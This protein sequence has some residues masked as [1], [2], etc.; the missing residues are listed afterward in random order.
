MSCYT[1]QN[2]QACILLS[3][4]YFTLVILNNRQLA[5]N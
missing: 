3:I 5:N 2:E 1:R 4:K